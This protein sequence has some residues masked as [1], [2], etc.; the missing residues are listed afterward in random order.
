MKH[1]Y[2]NLKNIIVV[3]D[4]PFFMKFINDKLQALGIVHVQTFLDP[5]IALPKLT[6]SSNKNDLLFID[7]QM[8]QID[9]IQLLKLLGERQFQGQ[10]IIMSGFEK[11]ILNMAEQIAKQYH[12]SVVGQ[13]HKPFTSA[14]LQSLLL[15]VDKNIHNEDVAIHERSVVP[16]DISQFTLTEA[17][18]ITMVQPQV[19]IQD[20]AIVGYEVLSRLSLEDE[21]II[22]PDQFIPA[23]EQSNRMA[24]FNEVLFQ[25]V[26]KRFTNYRD[27]RISINLSV[28]SLAEQD[29]VGLLSSY[30]QQY[31]IDPNQVVV[32]II[33]SCI[34]DDILNTQESLMRLRLLGVHLSIDDYGAGYSTM[35]QLSD[36]PFQ[37]LKIDRAYISRC[38]TSPHNQA[39]IKN[40]I[41]MAKSLNM[42]TVAEGVE[43]V[44]E[45]NTLKQLGVNTVQ[46]FYYSR[47]YLWN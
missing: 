34:A 17:N 35:K 3:D 10:I 40:T 20:E 14:Q 46:G 8:P 38:E 44:A 43:T 37:E 24:E 42:T 5:T 22:M 2:T 16:F 29:I 6:H 25:R 7:L 13:L 15:E 1:L 39:L 47:P 27:K 19:S 36:F 26:F 9:G 21:T 28:N 31:D 23:F 12:L 33:E 18:L 45:L 41:D 32:E 4:D 30:I 11:K